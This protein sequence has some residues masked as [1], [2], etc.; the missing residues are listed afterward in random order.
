M[1]RR[2]LFTLLG[3]APLAAATLRAEEP[4]RAPAPRQWAEVSPREKI[5]QRYFPNVSLLTHDGRE[6]RFYD[7]LVKDKMVLFNFMY[8]TCT[9]ICPTVMLN[10]AR[11]RKVLGDRVGRDI[12]LYSLTLKPKEDT[13]PVLAEYAQKHGLKPGWSLLT[14]KPE[15]VDLLRRTLGFYDSNPELDRD[16]SNH[17]GIVRYGNEPL[18]RWGAC[19]GMS[20]PEWIAKS[21]LWLDWPKGERAR[22]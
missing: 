22:A 10:L 4:P 5:R 13:V 19:P 20:E 16:T 18:M 12:F 2:E 21:I 3:T 8:A 1:N 7:D 6:V 14:G 9:G 17:I 11:V 15:D